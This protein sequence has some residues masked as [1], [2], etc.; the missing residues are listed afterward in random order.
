[1]PNLNTL[2]DTNL[3]LAF[4]QLRS[5]SRSVTFS[6]KT[7][8]FDFNTADVDVAETADIADVIFLGAKKSNRDKNINKSEFLVKTSDV[9]DLKLFDS[10]TEGEDVWSI[11]TIIR[12]NGFITMF[13]A[14]KGHAGE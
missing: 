2:I 6:R 14:V 7:V 1:M 10:F 3:K 13:I 4:R 8:G 9:V 12:D 11:D 5:L